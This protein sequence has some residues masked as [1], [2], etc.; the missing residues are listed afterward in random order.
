MSVSKA[1]RS[2]ELTRLLGTRN[3]YGEVLAELGEQYEHIVALNADLSGSTKT[4][5]FHEK[6]PHRFFNMGI[7]EQD[8]IGTAVGLARTGKIPFVSTFAI[9]AVGKP[10]EQI[11]QSVANPNVN[12]KIVATHGGITVGEDGAS[13]QCLEDVG[14]M[15]V[16]PNMTVIIPADGIETRKAVKAIVE[17][18]GPVYMRLS[19]MRFPVVF[20]ESYDFTIG[21]GTVVK[22]GTDVTI[23]ANGLMISQSLKAVED[24]GKEGI[25]AQIINIS[26]IKPLDQDLVIQAARTTGAVVT[27]EEHSIIGGLGSA[28]AEILSEHCPTPM[29][30]VGTKDR[31]GTSGKPAELLE[32]YQLNPQHIVLAVKEVLQQK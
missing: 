27:A 19:R 11:R 20:E 28:V 1:E 22:E 17:H 26:T 23:F 7:A 5:L 4:E 15:R 29:R 32:R 13:H 30:R 10:W 21:K 12:V 31:P 24:L 16:L 2:K 8:M 18:Q 9:F 14:I 3:A 6:F 25:S